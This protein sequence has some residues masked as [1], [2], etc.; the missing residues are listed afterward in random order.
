MYGVLMIDIDSTSLTAEDVSLI[1]QAQVGGVILFARNVTDAT[2]VRA[3]CDDIRYHNPDILIGVDQEGGR[4]ARLRDGFT[5]LPAMGKLG[6]LFDH[7]P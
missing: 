2:Q 4:V 5:K 6:E 3:L 1:K 7:D